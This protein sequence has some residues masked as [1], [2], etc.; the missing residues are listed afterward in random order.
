LT[1]SAPGASEETL[2]AAANAALGVLRV[3]AKQPPPPSVSIGGG[4][5][6]GSK[7][8][9]IREI[10]R[11]LLSDGRVHD[12]REIAK[13]VRGAGLDPNPLNKALDGHFER[14]ENVMG[15]PTYRDRSVPPPYRAEPRPDHEKPDWM[16]DR[17]PL[18]DGA[19]MH[20]ISNGL[21][22]G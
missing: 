9:Q 8:G 22:D 18:N 17:E 19:T 7:L 3:A 13:V 5:S 12:R 21:P 11:E 6:R 1:I 15:R 2:F 10:A 14:G 16:R 4:G 20:A